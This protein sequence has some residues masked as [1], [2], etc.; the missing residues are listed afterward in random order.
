MEG[1]SNMGIQ[2]NKATVLR[3]GSLVA[4]TR[5]ETEE[6]KLSVLAK[7][8]AEI[9]QALGMTEEQILARAR[10]ILTTL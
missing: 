2:D 5:L 3:Y 8:R 7:E 9:E 6:V 1:L 10:E 4:Q